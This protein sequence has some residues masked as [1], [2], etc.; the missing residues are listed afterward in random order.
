MTGWYLD[1]ELVQDSEVVA[2]VCDAINS[3]GLSLVC[4]GCVD[5]E[6]LIVS[7]LVSDKSEKAWAFCGS[8]S[9]Q[10]LATLQLHQIN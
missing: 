1:A 8:C 4:H 3:L 5:V 10:L 9:R 6:A 2:A 7:F